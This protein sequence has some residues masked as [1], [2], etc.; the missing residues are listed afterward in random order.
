M[1]ISKKKKKA[2]TFVALSRPRILLVV[3]HDDNTMGA[4]HHVEKCVRLAA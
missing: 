2:T 4:S 3:A 1:K